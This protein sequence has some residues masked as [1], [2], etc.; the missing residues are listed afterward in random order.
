MIQMGNSISVLS[1]VCSY[2]IVSTSTAHKSG[3]SLFLIYLYNLDCPWPRASQS[4]GSK[5]T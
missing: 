1:I 3:Q 2:K 5:G 4:L